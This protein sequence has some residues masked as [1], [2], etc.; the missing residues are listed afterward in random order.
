MYETNTKSINQKIQWEFSMMTP[1]DKR[2][3]SNWS[4]LKRSSMKPPKKKPA[5]S[6]DMDIPLVYNRKPTMD[7]WR[8]L[9]TVQKE[10]V[11]GKVQL[12]R[13]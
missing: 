1:G 9:M 4:K 6:I 11:L 3:I 5:I 7:D 13:V 12:P 2:W 8:K 10:Q